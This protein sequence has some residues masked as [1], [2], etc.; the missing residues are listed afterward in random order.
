MAD[1]LF[2]QAV[3]DEE[4]LSVF[5]AGRAAFVREA[6][7]SYP[8]AT[9]QRHSDDEL[10]EQLVFNSGLAAGPVE[11][12]REP[13]VGDEPIPVDRIDDDGVAHQYWRWRASFPLRGYLDIV[14]WWPDAFENDVTSDDKTR[15]PA[16]PVVWESYGGT[17]RA[18]IDT[19]RGSDPRGTQVPGGSIKEAADYLA[20]ALQTAN[21]QL[22]AFLT[23]LKAEVRGLLAERRAAFEERGPQIAEAVQLALVGF[24]EP[25]LYDAVQ[26]SDFPVIEA[27]DARVALD[28]VLDERTFQDLIT[29][30]LR[31]RAA[32]E[33]YP[34][35]FS[36]LN[37]EPISSLLVATLNAVFDTAHREV[38]QSHG[39]TDIMVEAVRD[40]RENAAFFGEAKVWGGQGDVIDDV[41]Q[42]LRYCNRAALESMLL[43][44]VKEKAIGPIIDRCLDA[45]AA[46]QGFAG[47]GQGPRGE[48]VAL[49][50]HPGHGTVI[51]IT[52]VFVHIPAD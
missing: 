40:D 47:W 44:Y 48:P 29:A 18:Y 34:A 9:F 39:R 5:L 28:K 16:P 14:S 10:V 7:L 22:A 46:V 51:R 3:R 37:E 41:A 45:I 25:V 30:T 31:W 52:P 20:A 2:T 15:H 50:P 24:G 49:V 17:A 33:R 32:V 12:G 42:V 23:D 19:P 11:L 6:A 8:A 1:R 38:F 35:A 36:A 27:A 4:R 13:E 26:P 43:Y 21:E